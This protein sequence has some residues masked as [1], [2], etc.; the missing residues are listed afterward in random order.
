MN[1]LGRKVLIASLGA[2]VLL[3]GCY[4][5]LAFDLA[6]WSAASAHVMRDYERAMLNGQLHAALS[7]AVGES[8]SYALTGNL[9]YRHDATQAIKDAHEAVRL[10]RRI[11]EVTPTS[12]GEVEHL[13]FL[14]QQV[15]LLRLTEGGLQQATAALAEPGKAAGSVGAAA[16]VGSIYAHQADADALWVTI[17]A[18]HGAEREANEQ[19][20]RDHSR[21]AQMLTLTGVAAF[22]LAIGVFIYYVRRRIVHPVTALARLT[23]RVAA[24]DLTGRAEVTRGDE[25]GQLQRS[26]NT[27]VDDLVT[28]RGELSALLESL[29]RARDVAEAADR[30]KSNFLA[31][32]SHEIRTPLHGVLVSLDLMYETAPDAGQ[33]E[34]ADT[35]RTSARSL[36]R[37]LNDLFDFSRIEAGVLALD[38]VRFELRP[39]VARMVDQH[40]KRATEKGVAVR[41]LVAE[42]VPT[43]ICGDPLR[44]GQLLANLVDNAVKFTEHGSIEVSVSMVVPRSGA[45]LPV[46]VPESALPAWLRL[47]VTDTGAGVPPQ[48]A[49]R[50]SEP[51]YQAEHAVS[52]GQGG[53]GLGLGIARQLASRMGGELG[54]ESVVGKG[55]SFWFTVRLQPD[56]A[57]QLPAP[58]EPAAPRQFPAGG[59]VL[60]AEDHRDIREVMART[61]RRRG[62][63]VMTAENG[64]VATALAS[65]RAF[66]LI[67]MDCR[68]P[69]MDGFEATLAIRALGGE[70][71]HVPI[72][73]LT[74]YGLTEP[75][76][77]Y[78]DA[79]FD[80]LLVKPY[81]LDDLEAV[82]HRWLALERRAQPAA[83]GC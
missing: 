13:G 22:A 26:F 57:T 1:N 7:R 56:S 23:G 68:M 52:Q 5:L 15:H 75:K 47:C 48:A 37:M 9:D 71:A 40:G 8:A 17:V 27:M 35:A 59:S 32:V 10:L 2:L 14:E 43:S 44:I 70:R 55:S 12:S 4:A 82:L 30:A 49:R 3:A 39:L 24:G 66:D 38:M 19:I 64:R 65:E 53:L 42:N 76:Q 67:L 50:I 21:R 41:C 60:L 74:A 61:L 36:L 31:N 28:Q 18:H 51:F 63:I 62:L 79:G 46:P 80:D 77:R 54:F 20:L 72:V 16:T 25:I 58:Q 78:L 81:T 6:K 34:L 73:A 69:V 83:V 33:R 29:A 11:A 45:S